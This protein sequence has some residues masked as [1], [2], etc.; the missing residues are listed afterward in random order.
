MT[1]INDYKKTILMTLLIA[2]L[3]TGGLSVGSL[4]QAYGG[5]TCSVDPSSVNEELN[6]GESI[7][8]PKTIDCVFDIDPGMVSLTSACFGDLTDLTVGISIIS[9]PT[10]SPLMLNEDIL[11]GLNAQPGQIATCT[12]N[13]GLLEWGGSESSS[14]EQQITITVPAPLSPTEID[15]K[16]G[17]D[18]NSINPRSMGVVPVAILGSDNFDVTEVDATNLEFGPN[19]ASPVHDF[20]DPDTFADHLEDVNEDGFTDLVSH[21]NQKETGLSCGDTEATLTGTLLDGTPFDGTD[22]V[23]IVPCR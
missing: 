17:S 5:L 14:A 22:S 11:V 20:T 12:L 10:S 3:L 18:P 21:Y 16:P 4:Q 7:T 15:I 8:I 2:P 19:S 6:P 23:R 1:R 9:G 13:F